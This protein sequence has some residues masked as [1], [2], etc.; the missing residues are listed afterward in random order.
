M[1]GFHFQRA[2]N[3]WPRAV[4]QLPAGTWIKAVDSVQLLSEA[5]SVNPGIKTVLRHWYDPGQQF[6]GDNTKRAREFLATFVDGT[7]LQHAGN[8]D[9]IEGFNEYWTYDAINGTAG[10]SQEEIDNR[11]DWALRLQEVWQSEY[12]PAHPEL[13]H[14]RLVIANT[15]I[16]NDTP[17]AVARLVSQF[18]NIL[19]YH[20]YMAVRE[21]GII[22]PDDWHWFSGR[23]TRV[24]E[25]YRR[26]GIRVNWLFTEG[27]ATWQKPDLGL[28][29]NTGWRDSRV[30]G[31][32]IN[33]YLEGLRY[34]MDRTVAWNKAN[35]NRAL[36]NVLFTTNDKSSPEW[37]SYEVQQPE[38]DVIAAFMND[39]APE[40][41]PPEPPSDDLDTRIWNDSIANQIA[42]GIS[43]NPGAGLQRAIFEFNEAMGFHLTPVDSERRFEG[44]AYQSAEDIA[45]GVR[46]VFAVKVPPEGQPWGASRIIEDPKKNSFRLTHWPTDSKRISQLFGDNPDYY[47][48]FGLPG[49][50]GVDIARTGV[51]LHRVYAAAEGRVYHVNLDADS[52]NYGV[53]VRVEH[54]DGYRTIYA[55]LRPGD[56]VVKT[57]D[58][59]QG[60]QMLGVMW[61][62]GNADGIHLHFG[63]KHE[64]TSPPEWPFDLIDPWPFLSSLHDQT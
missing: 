21:G 35:G 41:P 39:Y 25:I 24:D 29:P 7:F 23:W 59:V 47:K 32:D 38:M 9:A 18:G 1:I 60:G 52:H 13:A 54:V 12:K 57:G 10:H 31:G 58:I 51:T 45:T 36:G 44:Q 16:G 3:D 28:D 34:W 46:V 50:D 26:N 61:D 6:D 4:A 27:G 8:V 33:R 49:H 55:H 15:A 14:I 63:M 64:P 11:V 42:H 62:S 22:A 43:L 17:V 40:P 19:G 53:H 2:V 37:R 56:V 30:Y 5:K 48:K 20:P